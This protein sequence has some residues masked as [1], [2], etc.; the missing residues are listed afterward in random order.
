MVTPKSAI[1]SYFDLNL[2][3]APLGGSD[4]AAL[5]PSV[6]S[7]VH[8]APAILTGDSD[9]QVRAGT[10][11]PIG[12]SSALRT[13]V[14]PT[15]KED[16]AKEGLPTAEGVP[17]FDSTKVPPLKPMSLG[18]QLLMYF[19]VVIGVVFSSVVQQFKSGQVIGLKISL[20]SL[21]VA[22]VIA[23]VII[24]VVFQKLTVRP[25]APFLVRFGLFVQN[26]VF[27]HVITSSIGKT[28]A[29]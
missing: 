27:W 7:E 2:R 14:S 15:V 11:K 29:A 5:S 6:L 8:A 9:I 22:G 12:V 16:I 10:V 21:L 1:V 3:A 19:G 23:L 28:F 13:P 20:A 25:D 24:P 26:G 18:E 4:A 17:T